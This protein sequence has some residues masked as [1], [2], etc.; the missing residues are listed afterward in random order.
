MSD[1][2]FILQSAKI[3]SKLDVGK[4]KKRIKQ[5][6]RK[7]KSRTPSNRSFFPLAPGVYLWGTLKLILH[8]VGRPL[9]KESNVMLL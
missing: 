7:K 2:Q 8:T 5:K 4:K 1:N 6:R 3:E 9:P